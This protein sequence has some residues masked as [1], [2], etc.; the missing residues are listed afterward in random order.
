MVSIQSWKLFW[1]A[2]S[3]HFS[4]NGFNDC[5]Y[6]SIFF[7]SSLVKFRYL[8]SF[9]L[10]LNF[11]WWSTI[12]IKSH[13]RFFFIMLTSSAVMQMFWIWWCRQRIETKSRNWKVIFYQTQKSKLYDH[14]IIVFAIAT[15]FLFIFISFTFIN[16]R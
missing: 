8:L 6:Y 5:L 11:S 15:I 10:C 14:V 7:F 1:K 13:N 12:T 4:N 16:N 3:N 2:L 9:S